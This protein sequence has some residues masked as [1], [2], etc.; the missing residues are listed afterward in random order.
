VDLAAHPVATVRSALPGTVRFTGTIA[1]R[2][3]VVVGHG[4]TRTTYEPVRATVSVGDRVDAG[5]PIGV[6]EVAGSH[7]FPVACLHWGWL[8]GDT[9]LDPLLLV[10]AAP[11]RLLPQ[12][13]LTRGASTGRRS[14]TTPASPLAVGAALGGRQG[15]RP[16]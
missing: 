9:Y 8:R 11:V 16:G 2:G 12:A 10:G 4:G 6:L 7:C 3:V 15:R 13:G 1:G 5:R 14:T